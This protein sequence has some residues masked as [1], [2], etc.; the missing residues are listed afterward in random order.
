MAVVAVSLVVVALVPLVARLEEIALVAH[1]EEVARSEEIAPA[2]HPEEIVP[3]AR[4]EE[5]DPVA[6]HQVVVD[7]EEE[8]EVEA[9]GHQVRGRLEMQYSEVPHLLISASRPLARYFRHSRPFRTT[10]HDRPVPVLGRSAN[11]GLSGPTFLQSSSQRRG[12]FTTMTSRLLLR[13]TSRASKRVCSRCLSRAPIRAG[14]NTCRS[15]RMM[16]APGWFLPRS[17]PNR[18]TSLFSFS[19]KAKQSLPSA[20][21]P[22]PSPLL[23]RSSNSSPATSIRK[24]N[25]RK[26]VSLANLLHR[27]RFTNGDPKF[28]DYNFSPI[29]GAHNLVLQHHASHN[30]VRVGKNRYF[31]PSGLQAMEL[32]IGVEA[33]RG[34]FMSARPV[35]KELMVNVGV[36]MTAFY[37][38]G[39]L[40]QAIM[41]FERQSKGAMLKRF[42]QK[43]KVTTSHLGYKQTKPLRDIMTT[44]AQNTFFPCEEFNSPKMSV[45]QYFK[46]STYDHL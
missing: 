35:Y 13:L 28:R 21:R 30:G 6:T 2:A 3:V 9:L 10:P 46:K 42:A 32:S 12:S 11:L 41:E 27:P 34:F 25:H 7:S 15:L 37:K 8:A 19:R 16:G 24:T 39:N 29:V 23:A 38:P 5:V 26:L 20:T 14:R 45:E 43:L 40:A 31:F 4:P 36:C 33:W 18:S 1:P 44:T 17:C 22:I